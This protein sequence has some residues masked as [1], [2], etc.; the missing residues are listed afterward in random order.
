MRGLLA[1]W[2]R[3]PSSFRIGA[4]I[5]ALHLVVAATG[6][7]W[8]PYDY[9]QLGAG[10]PLSG[11][12][13]DHPFGIDQLGRDVFSRVIHGAHI[14]ILLSLSGTL[15]GLV[16]GS[17]LGLLSGYVRGWF[18]EVLMRLFDALN[19]IPFLILGL[20][21]VAAAG[22]KAAGNP[23]L[24]V[25]VIALIYAPRIGRMARTAALEIAIRDFI[26]AARLRGERAW[27]VI[28][29][30][31]LPNATGIL[32]VEFALRAGYAPVLIGSLGFL[33]FGMRPPSPEW[34]LMISENRDLMYSAP[35]AIVGPGLML[36]SL[37]VGLNLFTEGLARILGRSVRRAG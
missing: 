26:T 34:G 18:D 33:G 13:W 28:L 29:R 10:I 25:C 36:A 9:A 35:I 24:L 6:P 8:A 37:V 31:L 32:F 20:V 5:L 15:L 2:R 1:G 11:M 27:S 16:I 14:V 22:P 30:E 3:A 4:A 19:S 21:A 23:L 17:A 7:F 12:S